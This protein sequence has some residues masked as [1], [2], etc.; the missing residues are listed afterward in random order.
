MQDFIALDLDSDFCDLNI[1]S[2]WDPTLKPGGGPSES[3]LYKLAYQARKGER[4][5]IGEFF[6]TL[7]WTLRE[8]TFECFQRIHG[9]R[10]IRYEHWFYS[11]LQQLLG[12]FLFDELLVY[13]LEE[14]GAAGKPRTERPWDE[15]SHRL[16]GTQAEIQPYELA[17]AF[18]P[19]DWTEYDWMAL[20]R[21]L[22]SA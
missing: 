6:D 16:T 20:L 5:A 12:I 13:G 7:N 11:K 14:Y 18:S 3:A 1:C 15:G 17:Q 22:L 8:E 2:L 10:P 19:Q 21:S 9:P 4:F